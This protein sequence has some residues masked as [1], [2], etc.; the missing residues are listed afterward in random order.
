MFWSTCAFECVYFLWIKMAVERF[1][2]VENVLF[3]K[4]ILHRVENLFE[5]RRYYS[6]CEEENRE[7]STVWCQTIT[8]STVYSPRVI[9]VYF[10]KFYIF[11]HSQKRTNHYVV[12]KWSD[13][14]RKAISTVGLPRKRILFRLVSSIRSRIFLNPQPSSSNENNTYSNSSQ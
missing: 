11:M 3:S 12:L 6:L 14:I 10:V 7:T 1:D 4:R 9:C 2:I 8:L 13:Y 5:H